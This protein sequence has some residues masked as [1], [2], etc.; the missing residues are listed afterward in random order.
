MEINGQTVRY[1]EIEYS[2]QASS[3]KK[4]SLTRDDM[5]YYYHEEKRSVVRGRRRRDSMDD[6][7]IDDD[8]SRHLSNDRGNDVYFHQFNDTNII[9]F[10]L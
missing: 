5:Q 8:R 6:L 3:S 1:D 4:Q 10:V 7:S 9:G 2:A